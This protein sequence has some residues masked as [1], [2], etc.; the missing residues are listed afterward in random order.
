ME[1]A[2]QNQEDLLQQRLRVMF[3]YSNMPYLDVLLSAQ[4]YFEYLTLNDMVSSLLEYDMQVLDEIRL[5]KEEVEV[6][7]LEAEEMKL[8][9]EQRSLVIEGMKTEVEQKQATLTAQVAQQEKLS[10][11]LKDQKAAIEEELETLE[12]ES[13]ELKELIN[14]LAAAQGEYRGSGEMAW[15]VPSRKYVS[16]DYGMRV[17]PITG[18]YKMHTGIDIPAPKGTKIVSGAP[19]TVIYVSETKAYGKT[20]IVD[21]GGG[22]TTLYAH[23]SKQ[24]VK[25]GQEVEEGDKLGEVGTTGYSTGNH[26]HF[27]VR[28]NGSHVNPWNWVTNK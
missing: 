5:A 19:G 18:V 15:P 26:L 3:M 27:E 9:V 14:K 1:N 8:E 28:K 2:E 16:S 24:T 7:R 13:K 21:H 20:V 11:D 12:K 17:H 6:K 4:S 22:I 25:V 23:M 10:K